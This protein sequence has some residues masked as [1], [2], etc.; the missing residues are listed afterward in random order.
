MEP[1]NYCLS[2]IRSERSA[3]AGRA[4]VLMG[5][6][7]RKVSNSQV[8]DWMAVSNVQ[9]QSTEPDMMDLKREPVVRNPVFPS[10]RE[11]QRPEIL[12]ATSITLDGCSFTT[13][14]FTL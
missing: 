11:W 6:K 2:V 14:A 4:L 13:R 8:K 7:T 1:T 10:G 12:E 3:G 9:R 5:Y